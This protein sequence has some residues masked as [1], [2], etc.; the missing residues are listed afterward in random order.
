MLTEIS[1][2]LFGFFVVIGV[3]LAVLTLLFITGTDIPYDYG[4]LIQL[5]ITFGITTAIIVL[6]ESIISDI[7]KGL[8]KTLGFWF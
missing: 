8:I 5:P 4:T 3:I 2:F 7:Q 6:A 1:S